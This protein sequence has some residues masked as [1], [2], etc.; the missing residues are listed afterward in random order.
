MNT[1]TVWLDVMDDG[2]SETQITPLA[3]LVGDL[4]AIAQDLARTPVVT[5][6]W[7]QVIDLEEDGWLGY[8]NVTTDR[9]T[10]TALVEK[11]Y[12]GTRELEDQLV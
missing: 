8:V 5:V 4:D 1:V 10:A 7:S 3:R 11:W 6:D 2:A 12:D 9:E